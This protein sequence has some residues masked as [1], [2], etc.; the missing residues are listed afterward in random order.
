MKNDKII[1]SNDIAR[2]SMRITHPLL[3]RPKYNKNRITGS[4][5]IIDE[6]SSTLPLVQE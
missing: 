5:I 3:L 1:N 6:S 2:I 4:L